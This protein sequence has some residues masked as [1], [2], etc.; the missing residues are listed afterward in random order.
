[1]ILALCL[2]S[3]RASRRSPGGPE[4]T[5]L[6]PLPTLLGLVVAILG[7]LFL[8]QS[9]ETTPAPPPVVTLEPLPN[10]TFRALLFHE[11]GTEVRSR[12]LLLSAADTPEAR[13]AATLQALKGWLGDA[14]PPSLTVP[15]VFALGE[16]RVVLDFALSGAPQVS[17][18]TELQLL[19]SIRHTA[20]RQGVSDVFILV[21]GRT[22][23]TFLGQVALPQSLD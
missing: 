3:R 22:A 12:E 23:P 15:T 20:A 18:A 14:W 17:V 1:M 7:L 13:L 21:N 19:G 5:D 6:R 8:V 16:G 10:T 2:L 11:T 9:R 4:V